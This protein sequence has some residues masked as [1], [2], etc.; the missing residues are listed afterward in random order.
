MNPGSIQIIL[1]P[2]FSGKTTELLR[3]IRR[4]T[5]A[6]R[7]C[8]VIK[9]KKDTRYSADE[10]STHDKQMWTAKPAERLS[11]VQQYAVKVDVVGIDEGQ[12]F[13]D[14][15]EFAERMANLGK[16][17][18]VAALDGTFQRKPFGEMLQL[19]PLS[20]SVTKLNAVCMICFKDGAFTKRLSDDTKIEVIGG[21]DM[22]I[23]VCRNCFHKDVGNAPVNSISPQQNPAKKQRLQI[24]LTGT[25]TSAA[26]PTSGVPMMD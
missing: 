21:S 5:V 15:V 1:G 20:E 10:M 14:I 16:T 23:S 4:F 24:S 19:I 3:R 13:P 12:F 22:Y 18:I 7:T 25:S 6:N 17:V 8:L 26:T 2:M 9:Y 11:E